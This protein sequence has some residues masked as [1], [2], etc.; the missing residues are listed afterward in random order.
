MSPRNCWAAG[1]SRSSRCSS[2]RTSRTSTG[3]S[4]P[5]RR[6]SSSRWSGPRCSPP[7]CSSAA[8]W[9]R[10][11]SANDRRQAGPRHPGPV[12]LPGRGGALHART[13]DFRDDRLVQPVHLR[14][15]PA[16]GRD[17]ALVRQRAAG[18]GVP[19][20][21]RQLAGRGRRRHRGRRHAGHARRLRADALPLP[22]PRA[23]AL[24]PP[25][26]HHRAGDRLRGRALPALHPHRARAGPRAARPAVRDVHHGRQPADRGPRVRGGRDGSR[27]QPDRHVLPGHAPDHP[28]R[29]DRERAVRVR[30]VVGPGGG[31]AV[32]HAAPQQHPADRDVQLRAELPGP[33]AGGDLRDPHRVRRR[34]GPGGGLD[35]QDARVPAARRAGVA[36][37]A[38][39]GGHGRMSQPFEIGT[40]R[41]GPGNLGTGYI[42]S[43]YLRDGT[44]VRIPLVVAHGAAPGPMLWVGSA[45]HGDEIPGCE[46]IR[47]LMRER[48]DPRALRGTVVAAPVQHP[49][50]FLTCARLTVHDGV[51][52]NR[53]FPGDAAGTLTQRVAHDLFHQGVARSDAVLDIHSNAIGAVCFNIVRTGG[54]GP[55]WDG[56]W[57]LANAFGISVSVGPVGQLGLAGTL[58]DAAIQAGKPALTVELSGGYVW[59]EPSVRAG[60]LGVLNVMK[61]L[62]M[63]DGA[64]EPQTEVPVIPGRLTNRRYLVCDK[65]GLVRP[66]RPLGSKVAAGEPVAVL[67]DVF[68]EAV[69]TIASPI[70]GWVIT[71]PVAGNRTA[72]SGDT[73][74][75]VFGTA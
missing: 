60:L 3:P 27:G 36:P 18:A 11:V 2:T 1:A 8:A 33:H 14:D 23:R 39:R 24:L 35:P 67:Y 56:Q 38:P 7:T 47:R 42:D 52:I 55:A 75:F 19:G 41:V 22:P 37:G 46:V 74:A 4:R 49:V 65:G 16:A 17:T 20:G 53:V 21:T 72:V 51:N 29:P 30:D 13:A 26:P 9:P 6:S 71:Y 48:L 68:G 44:R 32:H 70:D 34:P 59:E 12:G 54:S 40:V 69:E 64:P 50:A 73:V 10:P 61:A 25:P 63:L 28:A 43:A 66:L 57:T 5:W 58:Q 31:L 45:V 62:G 15:V